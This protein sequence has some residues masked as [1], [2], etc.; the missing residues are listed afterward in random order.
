MNILLWL[1]LG[2]IAGGLA[3]RLSDDT[4]EDTLL[5]IFLGIFSAIFSGLVLT[6]LGVGQSINVV[7]I[8]SVFL[9][10][11]LLIGIRNNIRIPHKN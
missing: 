2:L 5:D 7:Q 8:F 4:W 11:V 9:G 10:A 3:S 6:K 1:G